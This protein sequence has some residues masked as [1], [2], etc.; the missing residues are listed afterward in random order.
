MGQGSLQWLGHAAVPVLLVPLV[1]A[2]LIRACDV[3][4]FDE[5]LLD[6]LDAAGVG[7]LCPFLLITAALVLTLVNAVDHPRR[8]VAL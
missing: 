8:S 5:H 4:F 3:F 7:P 6:K 1:A 2:T